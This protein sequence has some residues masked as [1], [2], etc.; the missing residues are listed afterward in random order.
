MHGGSP[1]MRRLE[2]DWPVFPLPGDKA[3]GGVGG[4]RRAA[5]GGR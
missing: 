3:E 2:Q 5:G 1:G 4:E